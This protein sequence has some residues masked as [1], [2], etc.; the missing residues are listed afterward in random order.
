V[1]ELGIEG[2]GTMRQE[3]IPFSIDYVMPKV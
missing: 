2:L 1:M 3:V